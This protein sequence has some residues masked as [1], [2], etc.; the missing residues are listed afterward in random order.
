MFSFAKQ[1]ESI[2]TQRFVIVTGALLAMLILIR[3]AGLYPTVFADEWHYSLLSRLQHIADASDPDYVYL[4]LFRLTNYCGDG[5]L[6]CA[7][8][9]NVAFFMLGVCFVYFCAR[10]VVSQGLAGMIALG[11]ILAPLNI[12]TAYY[13][14]EAMYFGSFWLLTWFVF[15]FPRNSLYQYGIGTG[16][17]IALLAM[18]KPHAFFLLPGIALFSAYRCLCD[19][20]DERLRRA[21]MI[22]VIVVVSAVVIRLT[23]GGVIAG[24]AGL[25]VFGNRYGSM[26]SDST[27][28]KHAIST[29]LLSAHVF[30]RHALALAVMFGVPIAMAI[31]CLSPRNFARVDA[32]DERFA[33][34]LYLTLLLGSLLI[35]TSVFTVTAVGSGPYEVL[36]RLHM[37]YYN[38]IFP[39]FFIVA[40]SFL[41]TP[42]PD[43]SKRHWRILIATAIGILACIALMKL[44]DISRP[45][46]VDGPEIRA[47]TYSPSHFWI[48]GLCGI[49]AVAMWAF[50]SKLGA[51]MFVFVFFPLFLLSTAWSLN[52]EMRGRLGADTYDHAGLFTRHYLSQNECAQLT[53]VG[54]EPASLFRTLFYIDNAAT[55]LV[56]LPPGAPLTAAAIPKDTEW[57]LTIGE[58]GKVPDTAIRPHMGDFALFRAGDLRRP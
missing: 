47:F 28:L 18:V 3:N 31:H 14:P 4:G 55:R 30:G 9:L 53:V 16:G 22:V 40:A 6:G 5:Y 54:S 45:I 17:L 26:A 33:A 8:V 1:F 12:Y 10:R 52:L 23:L 34:V 48:L 7:R 32:S 24:K 27:A 43:K 44:L 36:E 49:T 46:S 21:V 2:F 51:R 19:R 57:V 35:V 29:V 13:M 38:F 50:D 41:S 25:S 20:P 37:R 39:L 42:A 58:H 11:T 15:T 56:E